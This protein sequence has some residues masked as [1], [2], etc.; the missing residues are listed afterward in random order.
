MWF[1]SWP[2]WGLL[3]TADSYASFNSSNLDVTCVTPR[4]CP[5]VSDDV[6]ILSSIVTISYSGNG[7][8]ELGTTSRRVKNTGGISWE[9]GTLSINCNWSWSSSDGSLK[10]SSWVSLDM[11]NFINEDMWVSSQ[12]TWAS[13]SL[14][15]SSSV[16]NSFCKMLSNFSN[17]VHGFLLPST[18]ASSAV[19]IAHNDLLLWQIM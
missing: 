1:H 16:W 4:S 17:I 2:N 10:L 18:S 15:S 8:I 5:W 12:F 13:T 3:N 14:S 6:E 7:M 9:N 11:I 19:R